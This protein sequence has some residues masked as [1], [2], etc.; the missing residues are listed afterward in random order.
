MAF[1]L[2]GHRGARGHAPENTLASFARALQIGVTTLEADLAVTS[3]GVLVL[4]HD[5]RLNPDI[6]RSPDGSWLKAEGPAINH[7]SYANLQRYDVGRIDP[8]SRYA[9]LFPDQTPVDG[10]RIPT[11]KQLFE[12]G[13]ASSKPHRY[14]LETKLSP[15]TPDQ[16]PDP[17]TFARLAVE[18]AR[19]AKLTERVTIQSFDWRTLLAAKRI[20]PEIST[21]C[22][23]MET[24]AWSNLR[25]TAGQ[26]SPWLAGLD[27][28]RTDATAPELAYAAGCS[29]WS[30][31]WRNVNAAALTLSHRLGLK[32][33]PWTVNDPTDI[34]ALIDLGIDGLI[35][36]YPDRARAVMQQK[37][38]PLP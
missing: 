25:G 5:P 8:A 22:L 17:E 33:V 9:S 20:A 12:L 34:A 37:G 10:T 16:T 15:L 6:T 3:D 4:S 32:V 19:S 28:G 24:P 29:T 11:L 13:E 14:N 2:Q 26:L 1:D 7:L 23:T 18:A 35:T 36:D 31:F 38:L 30:P 27:A 21:V